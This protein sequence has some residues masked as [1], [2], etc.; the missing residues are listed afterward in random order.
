MN[1]E[2]LLAPNYRF[3][4]TDAE[5][6]ARIYLH[7]EG[8]REGHANVAIIT[9][10]ILEGT[11]KYPNRLAK[12]MREYEGYLSGFFRVVEAHN[13]IPNVLRYELAKLIA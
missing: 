13:K 8:V 5:T 3:T 11:L 2:I 9:K 10:D 12:Y 4:V 7:G 1:A 6:A